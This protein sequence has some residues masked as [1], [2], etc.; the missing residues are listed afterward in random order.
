MARVRVLQ[1]CSICE[2]GSWFHQ[3]AVLEVEDPAVHVR[4]VTDGKEGVTTLPCVETVSDDV[5]ITV[6]P[7]LF[8]EIVKPRAVGEE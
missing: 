7:D 2:K 1:G 6:T 3:G 4:T 5:A 8:P